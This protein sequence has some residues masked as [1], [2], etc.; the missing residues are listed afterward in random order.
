MTHASITELR[1][2]R[3][4]NLLTPLKLLPENGLVRLGKITA[5]PEFNKVH[6]PPT[7]K[8][9]RYLQ[10]AQQFVILV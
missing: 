8:G 5:T 9:T 2:K 4:L 1:Q 3:V 10:T 6:E 7:E